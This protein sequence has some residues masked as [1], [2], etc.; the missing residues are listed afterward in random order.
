[1]K[2]TSLFVVV[3]VDVLEAAEGVLNE[4]AIVVG[5]IRDDDVVVVVDGG[6]CDGGGGGDDRCVN[7]GSIR[8]RANVDLN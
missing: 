6:C 8:G 4:V 3:D 5:L 1:M 7:I 2:P